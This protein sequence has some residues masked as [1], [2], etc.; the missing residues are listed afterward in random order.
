V[1]AVEKALR[2]E[3]RTMPGLVASSSMAVAAIGLA[4][5]LDAGPGDDAAT[6]L[7]RELRLVM[8]ELHRQAGGDM[9]DDIADFL[10]RVAAPDSGH[11]AD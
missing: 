9:T 11:T 6:R 1:K 3:L 8:A 10:A 4:R 2:A 7:T 5:R